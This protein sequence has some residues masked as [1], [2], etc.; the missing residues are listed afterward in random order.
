MAS[1]QAE[2][3]ESGAYEQHPHRT[4]PGRQRDRGCGDRSEAPLRGRDL[5]WLSA[6]VLFGGILGP[7]LLMGG[8]TVTPASTG[9]LLLNTEG[10]ATMAIAW[11]V[12]SGEYRASNFL[13][14][15]GDPCRRGRALLPGSGGHRPATRLRQRPDRPR[16]RLLGNRQQSCPQ[17]Q[18]GRWVFGT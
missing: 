6:I 9:S 5:P 2:A 11:V 1:Q 16:L 17:A 15:D 13:G 4:E 3:A 7:A 14:R 18:R 10:L 8:L 12:F